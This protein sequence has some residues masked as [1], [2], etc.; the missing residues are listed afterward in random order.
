[1]RVYLRRISLAVVSHFTHEEAILLPD[2]VELFYMAGAN[3]WWDHYAGKFEM[4][5]NQ[6]KLLFDARLV[7][8]REATRKFV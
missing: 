8:V 3:Y 4:W 5:E 1:M 6:A 2:V 7:G